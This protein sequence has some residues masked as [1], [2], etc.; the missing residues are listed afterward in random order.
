MN[1]DTISKELATP[2][3]TTRR[4]AL[5]TLGAGAVG[6]AGLRMLTGTAKAASGAGLDAAV[7]QFALNLEYLEAEFYLYATTDKGFRPRTSPAAAP[8][9]APP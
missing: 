1:I 4:Q 5:R 7:L 9:A 8:K 2:V 6:L 3:G